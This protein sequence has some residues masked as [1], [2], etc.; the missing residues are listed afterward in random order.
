MRDGARDRPRVSV[1]VAALNEAESLHFVLPWLPEDVYEVILVD[2]NS[3][4]YTTQI[5]TWLVP[6]IRII[7][8]PGRG[9]GNALR[10]GFEAARGDIIV[11]IDADGST[12]PVEIPLFIDA[13][14]AGADFAKGSRLLPGAGSPDLTIPRRV[15]TQ[16]L[17]VIVRLFFGQRY[18]DINYGFN[19]FWTRMLPALDLKGEGF[20]IECEMA[21]RATIARLNVVEIPCYERIRSRGEAHLRPL[22]DG[23]RIVREIMR[24]AFIVAAQTLMVTA[25]PPA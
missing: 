17:C 14:L 6:K 3:T 10:T 13:L 1:V 19:A 9:K 18:T 23:L 21:L 20:E 12:D 2:G 4:D 24:Q 15:V 7:Q 22:P 11:A 16:I 8:Q 5:A 25:R